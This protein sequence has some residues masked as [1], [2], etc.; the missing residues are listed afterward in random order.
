MIGFRSRRGQEKKGGGPKNVTGVNNL[1]HQKWYRSIRTC[2]G[3]SVVVQ[4]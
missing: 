4:E 3:S 2:G 1:S